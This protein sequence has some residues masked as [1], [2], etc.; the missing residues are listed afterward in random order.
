MTPAAQ[1][2]QLLQYEEKIK[3][4]PLQN[5]S[6]R[7]QLLSRIGLLYSTQKKFKEAVS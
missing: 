3:K 5:D 2:T 4:C 6:V 7:A 1:L